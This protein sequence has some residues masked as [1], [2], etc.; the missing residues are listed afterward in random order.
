MVDNYPGRKRLRLKDYDYSQSGVYF[1]T[2]CTQDRNCWLGEIKDGS[3][4]LSSAGK[5]T[6][7]EWIRTAEL[8]SYILLDEYMIMPNHLHGI[9]I[10]TERDKATHRVATTRLIPDSLGSIIGQFKSIVTK[11]LRSTGLSDFCWQRNYYEHVIRNE[12]DLNDIREYI[13]YNP[14]KWLE[15][16]E[17]PSI[18]TGYTV[19]NNKI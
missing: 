1:I 13:S 19:I 6:G 2:I 11:R 16:H 3:M 5:I 9:I 17:N 7:E 10:I 14:Q 8:R 4:L 18:Q 15:D 12:S